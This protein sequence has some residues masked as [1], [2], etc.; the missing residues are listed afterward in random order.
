MQRRKLSNLIVDPWSLAKLSVPFIILAVM[1]I[2]IVAMMQKRVMTALEGTVLY[3]PENLSVM[4]ALHEMQG[5]VTQTGMIGVT[6]FI[7][8][9]LVLW[10]FFSHRIFGP[11]VPM[12]RHVQSLIKGDYDSRIYPRA[13]DEFKELIADLNRLAEVLEKKK[14]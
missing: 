4:N 1:S 7:A 13:S 8:V 12:R 2:G 14:K 11:V 10:I 5:S 3:G 9:S 6:V